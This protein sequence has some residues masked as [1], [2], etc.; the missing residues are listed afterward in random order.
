MSITRGK[1]SLISFNTYFNKLR[2]KS[3]QELIEDDGKRMMQAGHRIVELTKLEYNSYV[4]SDLQVKK[5]LAQEDSEE[6]VQMM[7]EGQQGGCYWSQPGVSILGLP[8]FMPWNILYRIW[9]SCVVVLDL[10]YTAFIFPYNIAWSTSVGGMLVAEVVFAVI[11]FVDLLVNLHV[12]YILRYKNEKRVITRGGQIFHLY[13]F[14][15]SLI[16]D[17][18]SCIPW[19]IITL[20]MLDP[21]SQDNWWTSALRATRILRLLRVLSI[22]KEL[23]LGTFITRMNKL[24]VS[25]SVL[26]M[27]ALGYCAAVLVNILGCC[28]WIVG[29]N[30]KSEEHWPMYAG[31]LL[32]IVD[33]DNAQQYISSIY[34]VLT[35]ITTTG[36]GDIIPHNTTEQIWAMVTMACGALFFAFLIGSVVQ[37]MTQSGAAARRAAKFKDKIQVVEQ[38]MELNCVSARMRHK[39]FR[40]Y[41]DVWLRHQEDL[42]LW[43][44]I[45]E[46]T[47]SL[48]SDLLSEMVGPCIQSLEPFKTITPM[49][50]RNLTGLLEPLPLAP[51]MDVCSQGEEA[52]C[53]W[54]LQ[55]GAVLPFRNFKPLPLPVTA[56]ALLGTVAL[57]GLPAAEAKL[58]GGPREEDSSI[59]SRSV[60]RGSSGKSDSRSS[61]N[62]FET[63]Y[64]GHEE[65]E[66]QEEEG[67][68]YDPNAPLAQP[69]TLRTLR[70]CTAFKLP[71]DQLAMVLTTMNKADAGDLRR[72]LRATLHADNLSGSKPAMMRSMG[73]TAK[74]G[75]RMAGSL[76]SKPRSSETSVKSS[77]SAGSMATVG[78]LPSKSDGGLLLG[79]RSSAP[80]APGTT[81]ARSQAAA[82]AAAAPLSFKVGSRQSPAVMESTASATAAGSDAEQGFRSSLQEG[83]A[84]GARLAADHNHQH[85][86]P[87]DDNASFH[88]V[89]E[90]EERRGG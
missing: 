31:G 5:V 1:S 63:P 4:S 16:T 90:G 39:I 15:G 53:L 23:I 49:V 51:E 64:K 36:Y 66:E 77:A 14:K 45:A 8:V 32:D 19:F 17:F 62:G 41:S 18:I 26:F 44:N 76:T 33:A 20:Y 84:K 82:A 89:N 9:Y 72:R 46:L 3:E 67:E 88:S 25:V 58:S 42:E 50:L 65:E 43:S 40:Y 83:Q 81:Q 59:K 80:A 12:P 57:R 47:P 86:Y 22:M 11:F 2:S 70:T 35:T 69:Y 52:G 29:R 85:N 10:T 55:E 78:S 27:L 48:K 56:P 60:T 28:W 34:Y 68:D 37:I 6:A 13:L 61:E 7:E 79:S 71:V 21:D 73:L 54:I 24:T 74:H 30:A 75:G 87:D 38:F